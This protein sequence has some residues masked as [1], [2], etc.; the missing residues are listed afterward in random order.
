MLVKETNH[1]LYLSIF[2][3]PINSS[4]D[5]L[6]CRALFRFLRPAFR[7]NGKPVKHDNYHPQNFLIYYILGDLP[8]Q[9]K[10]KKKFKKLYLLISR[11]IK[12]I[13]YYRTII[14]PSINLSTHP[15]N[16]QSI[17]NHNSHSQ[18][19]IEGYHSFQVPIILNYSQFLRNMDWT[20]HPISSF[21]HRHRLP[22]SE[23]GIRRVTCKIDLR[24][25]H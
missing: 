16:N 10:K 5:P 18:K 12:S 25:V 2:Y 1:C 17:D 24:I 11:N 14:N 23:T 3:Q 20:L 4:A 8:S 6:E 21:K 9:L 19:E 15:L 22:G 7:Q 13:D